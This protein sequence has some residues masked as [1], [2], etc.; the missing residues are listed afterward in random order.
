MPSCK[1]ARFHGPHDLRVE[2]ADQRRPRPAD[3]A[4]RP[5]AV[6]LCGTDAH[7]LAGRFPA[8]RGTVLGHEIAGEIVDLG[9]DVVGL[10]RG[11][12]VAVEPHLYCGRCHFCRIGAE[13]LCLSK[14]AFGIH[15]DG[16]LATHLVV[17]GRCAYKVPDSIGPVAAA[18]CEPLGCCVHGMDRLA[19]R[20]GD[21]TLIIG[22]GPAGLLLTRLAAL[23]GVSPVVVCDLLPARRDAAKAFGADLVVDPASQAAPRIFSDATAG[24]GFSTVIEAVGTAATIELALAQAA[25]GGRILIFGAAAQGDRVAVSPFEIFA[26]ELTIIGTVRNPYTHQRALSLLPRI[27]VHRLDIQEFDLDDVHSAIEAQQQGIGAKIIV[28]P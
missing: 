8:A 24:L 12:L 6:G 18:L 7:I 25:Q 10:A 13:H 11:D 16:G 22:A 5:V 3:V 14:Q 21:S 27:P 19:P 1:V 26:K 23:R 4:I 15:L 9:D 17:P 28:C 2:E 20:L